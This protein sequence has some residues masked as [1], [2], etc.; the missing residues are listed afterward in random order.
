MA[1]TAAVPLPLCTD[2]E[3]DSRKWWPQGG[4]TQR[5]A[6]PIK[7]HAIVTAGPPTLLNDLSSSVLS[8]YRSN[9]GKNT[10]SSKLFILYQKVL[11]MIQIQR[12]VSEL[13]SLT[14]M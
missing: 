3:R 8:L 1:G 5:W 2:E 11:K 9:I 7:S 13:A 6:L 10:R 14:S 12:G 4:W